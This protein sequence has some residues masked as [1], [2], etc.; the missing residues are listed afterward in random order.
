[1]SLHGHNGLC[2]GPSPHGPTHQGHLTWYQLGLLALE[3]HLPLRET[4]VGTSLKARWP[5]SHS[6]PKVRWT[7]KQIQPKHLAISLSYSQI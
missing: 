3:G 4:L 2:Q 7:L 5:Q 1:M 6:W